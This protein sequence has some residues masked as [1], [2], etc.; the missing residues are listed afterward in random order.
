MLTATGAKLLDFGL[1]RS[2]TP[3]VTLAT[4]TMAADGGPVQVS[5]DA[6]DARGGSRSR[7]G[8]IIFAATRLSPIYRVPA[9]GGITVPVTDA[10]AAANAM[11]RQCKPAATV[12][13]LSDH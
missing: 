8:M 4:L 3:G 10:G 6:S 1:A 9:D 7:S 2:V 13:L 5:C 11:C 12:C